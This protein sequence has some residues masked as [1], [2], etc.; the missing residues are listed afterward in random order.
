MTDD[1][2]MDGY[3]AYP[4]PIYDNPHPGDT[5]EFRRWVDGWVD[6]VI[7]DRSCTALLNGVDQ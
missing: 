4:C 3:A 7:A 1:A 5:V 2:Y 6:G